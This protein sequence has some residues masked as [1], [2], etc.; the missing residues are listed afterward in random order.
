MVCYELGDPGTNT[1]SK[2]MHSRPFKAL[3]QAVS[4]LQAENE[5]ENK[6]RMS[7]ELQSPS[8]PGNDRLFKSQ[9]AHVGGDS[10]DN[11]K[12]KWRC[13]MP[14]AKQNIHAY[15]MGKLRRSIE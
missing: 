5:P 9:Y 13:A 3:A 2:S 11:V 12:S 7:K 14:S 10:C 6:L 8:L 15:T 1:V 4:I